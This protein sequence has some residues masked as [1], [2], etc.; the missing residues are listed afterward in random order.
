MSYFCDFTYT[1]EGICVNG[2][3]Y[4]TT[5]MKW[6]EGYT[7]KDY[8]CKN[9]QSKCIKKLAD[10]F[11]NMCKALHSH[12]FAHGDLQHGNIMVNEDGELFLIDYDSVYIPQLGEQNDIIAGL[13]DYQHPD[14]KN[15]KYSSEKLDYFSELIIYISLLAISENLS[16][17]QEY[18]IETLNICYLQRM[19]I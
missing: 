7:L 14:R 15:N 18:D 16:L 6:I 9:P 11:L 2:R 8:I 5:R 4:P 1:P 10:D 3:L 13:A 12:H 17:I 19:I